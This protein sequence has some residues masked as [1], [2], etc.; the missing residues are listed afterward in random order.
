MD[1]N[2]QRKARGR[3]K[4]AAIMPASPTLLEMPASYAGFLEGLKERIAHERIKAVLSANA[5]MV[6]LY[7][8]IGESILAR[9]QEEGWGSRVIDRLSHDLKASFPDMTG[10]SP[11]NLKY[12]RKFA[13]AWPDRAIVQGALAQIT[14]Y[15]NLALLEKVDS[16]ENR[17]WYSRKAV[18]HGWSRNILVAQIESRL[19]ERQG[20]AVTNFTTT[21]PPQDSDMAE[22][23]FKDPYVFD[24]LGTADP[25]REAELEQK[26]IDHIQQFLL[27][28]GQGFAFVGRQVPM[29]IGDRDFYLDLLFYHLQ[30]RCYV[31]VELKT[32]RFEAEYVGKMN[33]YLSAVDDLL[34]HPDD[35]PSI[36]L[37]LVK[38]KEQLVVEYALDGYTKPIGVAQWERQ[39]SQSLPEELKSSLPTVEEL[40]AELKE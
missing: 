32:G 27:E 8:D 7:W 13:D 22:Q 37:L 1:G 33:F 31:V 10:F 29:E 40:E 26:L 16:P 24:F 21:L 30:L 11:R 28:L 39:I 23:V 18:E 6:L 36:G 14:W 20:Q 17:L 12:M 19:H 5:A 9:Q 3:K 35:K 25:R 38:G 34:R 2:S 15:H 4:A